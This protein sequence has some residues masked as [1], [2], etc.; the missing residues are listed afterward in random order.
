MNTEI[1]KLI[2][3]GH[4][5]L[6]LSYFSRGRVTNIS[7]TPW[8]SP[9]SC[10]SIMRPS[11]NSATMNLVP[12]FS[13]V[14]YFGGNLCPVQEQKKMLTATL[15]HSIR[16]TIQDCPP[17]T[18]IQTKWC[19]SIKFEFLLRY[20]LDFTIPIHKFFIEN[21]YFFVWTQPYKILDVD[22]SLLK[23]NLCQINHNTLHLILDNFCFSRQLN[24]YHRPRIPLM[25]TT[26]RIVFC[27][28]VRGKKLKGT[29]WNC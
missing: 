5:V 1:K 28:Q 29:I 23:L 15:Q 12:L 6:F 14:C 19:L 24:A 10:T 16:P 4:L 2:P 20:F 18:H 8:E 22:T 25:P 9:E 3:A 26:N 11:C 27:S 7:V 17:K 21:R 13:A